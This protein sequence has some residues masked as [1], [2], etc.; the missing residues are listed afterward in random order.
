MVAAAANYSRRYDMISNWIGEACF[1]S[2]HRHN[3]VYNTC[4]EDPRID[5]QALELNSDDRVMLITSAGCNALDYA[6]D[7]PK[8]IYAVDLNPLQNALLELKIACIR[9]LEYEDFFALFGRGSWSGWPST[10]ANLVRPLLKPATQNIWDSRIHFFSGA[11]RRSSFYFHGSSG[12]FAWAV[13]GYI[14]RIAKVR[15]ALLDMLD[16]SDVQ[17]QRHIFESK[18]LGSS[19]WSP[20][21]RWLIRRDLTMSMLGVPRAQRNQIDRDVKGGIEQFIIDRVESVFTQLPLKDNYFWRVYLTGE[22]SP[23]CCPEYLREPCFNRLKAGDVDCISIHDNSVE[24]FLR[25]RSDLPPI[26]RFVLL[27]HMDWICSKGNGALRSEWEA[28]LESASTD[29]RV[30]WRSAGLSVDFV[31]P[32][33]V[34]SSKGSCR[35]GDR[36]VYHH[37]LAS[38]LHRMD[39]VHTYGSFYIADVQAA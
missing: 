18:D 9:T 30:L 39:R 14:N 28:I 23:E 6:L 8:A 29:A 2:I 3:L 37:E 5:R 7:S 10:Y 4:W 16:A 20:L 31:D 19:I 17:E 11:T 25:G 33:I 1:K 26:S 38:Q 24:Q 22:Y 12:Y 36:L 32:L 15:S 34:R 35:V 21:L 27:D 13:N